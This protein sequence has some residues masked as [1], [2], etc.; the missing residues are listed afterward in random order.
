MAWD[1]HPH[2][3]DGFLYI[4]QPDVVFAAR[5]N[6]ASASYPLAQIPFDGVTTGAY[7]DLREG[8]TVL[9][10]ST[11]GGYDRGRTY[12]RADGYG[13]VSSSDTLNVGYSSQGSAPGTVN[14]IDDSYITVVD[15]YEPWPRRGR[16]LD[17]FVYKDYQLT[18]HY[19]ASPVAH[20]GGGGGLA[21]MDVV[22]GSN[23]LPVT[24]LSAAGSHA[25]APGASIASVSW[26]FGGATS[27]ATAPDVNF[28]PGKRWISL[29]VTDSNGRVS[30]PRRAL[31]VALASASDTVLKVSRAAWRLTPEGVTFDATL[32]Q[33]LDPADYLPGTVVIWQVKERRAGVEGSLTGYD[34]KF[35][36]WL[37]RIGSTVAGG[38]YGAERVST[39]HAVDAAGRYAA[40]RAFPSTMARAA[41]PLNAYQMIGAN[42]DRYVWWLLYYHTFL[43][44]FSDFYWSRD[45]LHPF[46]SFSSNGGS[47]YDVADHLARG[48]GHRFTMDSR[49]RSWM[50][51]DPLRLEPDDRTNS[52]LQAIGPDDVQRIERGTRVLPP[53]G[54]TRA[55]FTIASTTDAADIDPDNPPADLNVIAPGTV[56][57]VGLSETQV[58][59][60][61]IA[62]TQAEALAR[63]G[64]DHARQNTPDERW[65]ISLNH[66]GDNGIE[67]A[68]M[69]WVTVTTDEETLGWLDAPLDGARA[70]PLAVDYHYDDEANAMTCALDVEPESSGSPAAPDDLAGEDTPPVPEPESAWLPEPSGSYP[71]NAMRIAANEAK[72]HWAA[73]FTVGVGGAITIDWHSRSSGKTGSGGPGYSNPFNPTTFYNFSSAGL[74]ICANQDSDSSYGWTNP[75]SNDDLFGDADARCIRCGGSHLAHGWGMALGN[76]NVRAI[77]TDGWA[78]FTQVSYG[79]TRLSGFWI[80]G[81]DANHLIFGVGATGPAN[82]EWWRSTDGGLTLGSKLQELAVS[83]GGGSDDAA[84]ASIPYVRQ[85]GS[86]NAD[87]TDLLVY[88]STF[89]AKGSN[90]GAGVWRS[91]D[92]LATTSWDTLFPD[93]WAGNLDG[94]YPGSGGDL[95]VS[96]HTWDADWMAATNQDYIASSTDGGSTRRYAQAFP[97]ASASGINGWPC[98]DTSDPNVGVWVAWSDTATDGGSRFSFDNN[99]TWSGNDPSDVSDPACSYIECSLVGFIPN[100]EAV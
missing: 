68:L 28:A 43:P 52:V 18:V 76:N 67:P 85:D 45:S 40:L 9:I 80:C 31:V 74:E 23:L 47:F 39:I 56:E 100:L 16:M 14:V 62:A 75:W 83:T 4:L 1:T 95:S 70:L 66:G 60:P 36:G 94:F 35:A 77:T 24:D 98:I 3:A 57:G 64:Q 92:R 38:R 89:S 86:P 71:L 63:T 73:S 37:D 12:V 87:D 88:P 26:A 59:Y 96:V 5:V 90:R 2:D 93:G 42:L 15:L 17:G 32:Y 49:G 46:S 20:L 53:V 41:S 97:G 8:M 50:L 27:E 79:G 7:T 11:A 72:A 21:I 29:S 19:N 44:M 33:R 91:D 58:G 22:N 13:V 34:I 25:T 65:K 30:M 10:G 81:H 55:T 82:V 54:V 84:W 61:Q 51:P 6:L 99:Q 69:Q 48:G 78:T